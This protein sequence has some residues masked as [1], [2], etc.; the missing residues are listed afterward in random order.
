MAYFNLII[1]MYSNFFKY[2]LSFMIFLLQYKNIFI[3]YVITYLIMSLNYP[4]KSILIGIEKTFSSFINIIL[5][6]G[7][8]L[9]FGN[10][11]IKEFG[12]QGTI[13][14]LTLSQIIILFTNLFFVRK[15]LYNLKRKD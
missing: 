10:L 4:L 5:S 15:S 13:F 8:I 1:F 11:M 12:L 3:V 2:Y 9:I 14:M 7:F 6:A